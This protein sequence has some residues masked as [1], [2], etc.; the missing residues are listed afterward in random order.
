[1]EKYQQLQQT[2]S[3]ENNYNAMQN[4]G[5]LGLD[6]LRNEVNN[7]FADVKSEINH[8]GSLSA[9]LAALHPMQYDPQAPNQIMAGFG[10]YRNKQA[11]AVGMSHYF[12]DNVLMTAG[13]AIGSERRVKTMANVG[14]AWK[15]G[16]GGSSS[17]T[18]TPQYIMQDELARL[19]R[20][21][22]VQAKENQE[23]KERVKALEEKLEMLLNKK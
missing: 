3:Q 4:S 20:E 7:R 5:A 2:Q 10:H 6:N 14:I 1:M 15:I 12:S 13:V 11:V 19:T 18:N 8:V 9:A 21:N 22:K 23:L 16:K 17:A